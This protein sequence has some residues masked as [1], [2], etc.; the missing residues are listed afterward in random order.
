M[1]KTNSRLKIICSLLLL[2]TATIC[3]FAFVAQSVSMDYVGPF[4]FAFIRFLIGG[5][6]L[7][8]VIF[9]MDSR[10]KHQ[11]TI[12]MDIAEDWKL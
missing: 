7:L 12:T 2:L 10:K 11:D 9:F 6:V 3:G 1:T 8:P 5:F 4:T